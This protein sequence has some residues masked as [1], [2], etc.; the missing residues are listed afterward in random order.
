MAPTNPLSGGCVTA[1]LTSDPDRRRRKHAT[2]K[3]CG[4]DCHA[5]WN[6]PRCTQCLE[7]LQPEEVVARARRCQLDTTACEERVQTLVAERAP[8][9]T[10]LARIEQESRPKPEPAKNH[11]LMRIGRCV[12]CGEPTKGGQF[13]PGHDTRLKGILKEQAGEGSTLA[14]IELALRD[15]VRLLPKTWTVP[16]DAQELIDR[17]QQDE[18]ARAVFLRQ[19]FERRVGDS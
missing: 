6:T 18:N 12:H 17:Y 4:C 9:Y 16:T 14:W 1:S 8:E 19:Q 7:V 2:C 15:W 3:G 11:R 10:Q 13:L 5:S